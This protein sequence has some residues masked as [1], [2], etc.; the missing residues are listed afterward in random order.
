MSNSDFQ[1]VLATAMSMAVSTAMAADLS[2]KDEG[3][4]TGEVTRIEEDGTITLVSPV[5]SEPLLLSGD[6]VEKVVFDK[7]PGNTVI[8]D[9]RLELTNGDILPVKLNSMENGLL[10][11]ECPVLGSL[12]IP[13]EAVSSLQLGIIP[14]KRIYSGPSDFSGWKRAAGGDAAWEYDEGRFVAK[15]HGT[16]SRDVALPEKF[17]FKFSLAWRN[18]PNFQICFAED[19]GKPNNRYL[20]EFGGSGM[21]LYRESPKR[22][23]TVIAL[24]PG[25]TERFARKRVDVEIRADRS[26]GLLEL[27]VD[28]ELEGRFTDPIKPF[29]VGASLS[30]ISRASRDS[31]QSV[32]DIRVLEWDD[33]GDRHR[34]EERGDGGSDSLIGRYGERFGGKLMSIRVTDGQR[35]YLFKSDFQNEPLELPEEEVS[36]V[37]LGA[38][39][40]DTKSDVM[41]G[42]I[43]N[44]RGH[45]TMRLS[46]C[47]LEADTVKAV[48]PLLGSLEFD[49]SGIASIERIWIP[50]AK[51]HKK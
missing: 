33:R 18:H 31:R 49:R 13:R 46:S 3:K 11:F 22:A 30:L 34:S 10:K 17:I 28:G 19:Q 26:R 16:L 20:I 2:L 47:V 8:P 14:E 36:T 32:G 15:G 37:F 25:G 29:P 41:G 12:A 21:G 5:S 35:V 7:A 39:A 51:P 27:R 6:Q 24:L 1:R 23:R 40:R 9:Q 44:L 43:V 50:K 38:G 45:G 42:L 4:L 48:H